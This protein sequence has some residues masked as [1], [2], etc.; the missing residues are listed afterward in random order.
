[1]QDYYAMVTKPTLPERLSEES[2]AFM[3]KRLL[4]KTN[5]KSSVPSWSGVNPTTHPDFNY[6]A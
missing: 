5:L 3:E 2:K 1:M 6:Y 4:Q